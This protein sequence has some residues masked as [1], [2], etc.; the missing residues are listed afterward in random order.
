MCFSGALPEHVNDYIGIDKYPTG[1][2]TVPIKFI[3]A[4]VHIEASKESF[5]SL[6]ALDTDAISTGKYL[7]LRKAIK[8]NIST[9]FS[10]GNN[11]ISCAIISEYPMCASFN[12]SNYNANRLP[13]WTIYFQ[14]NNFSVD[15]YHPFKDFICMS[16]QRCE[17]EI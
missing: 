10:G 1:H 6:A 5:D 15:R 17:L 9:C 16:I 12:G 13:V 14:L 4:G 3:A 11:S 2:C 7:A 8:S